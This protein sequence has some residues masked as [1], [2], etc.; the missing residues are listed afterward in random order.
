MQLPPTTSHLFNLSI[1][2]FVNL[3]ISL[4]IYLFS[5]QGAGLYA[6]ADGGNGKPVMVRIVFDGHLTVILGIHD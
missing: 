4:A 3:D 5:G 2:L 6:A 1:H